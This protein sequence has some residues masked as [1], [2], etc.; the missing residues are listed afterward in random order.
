MHWSVYQKRSAPVSRGPPVDAVVTGDGCTDA[1]VGTG[2]CG[3]IETAGSVDAV[4]WVSASSSV[5][6][7]V[8]LACSASCARCAAPG[9]VRSVRPRDEGR[10]ATQRRQGTYGR[11]AAR[12]H[13][14]IRARV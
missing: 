10:A 1:D 7:F 8:P 9:R 14:A 12:L 11:L 4:G 5:D 6:M 3:G 2:A 13:W